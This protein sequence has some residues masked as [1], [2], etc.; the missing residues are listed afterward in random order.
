[1]R[2]EES[3]RRA[4]MEKAA[5]GRTNGVG[6]NGLWEELDESIPVWGED[7]LG[8]DGSRTRRR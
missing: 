2:R 3:K 4:R 8:D 1:M 6:G 5:E 7:V